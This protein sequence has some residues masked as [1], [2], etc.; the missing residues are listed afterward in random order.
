M[1]QINRKEEIINILKKERACKIEDLCNK[2][3]VSLST[4]HRDLN[5]L[6]RE[7]SVKKVHG[8]V[9]I[10]SNNDLEI[11]NNIRLKKNVDL[12]TSIAIKALK[13]VEEGDYIFLDNSTTCYYFAKA[14]SESNF[15]DLLIITNSYLIP[16]LFFKNKEIEIISTGG[17]L[18]KEYSCFARSYAID[19]ISKF[20]INKFFFSVAAISLK[21]EFGDTFGAETQEVKSEMFK[22]S[23]K[24]ICLV[25]STKFGSVGHIN[26]P[27]PLNRVNNIIT[28]K[29][30]SKEIREKF[31]KLGKELI[32]A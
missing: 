18:L 9:V 13:F 8:G 32:I 29:N 31:I 7:G 20:S 23:E 2:L 15:K 27:F 25:D 19:T 6:E 11:R 1:L 17:L 24:H 5:E 12:K 4:I 30:C 22:R 26:I 16:G 3:E 14:L 28:D 10:N 21:G